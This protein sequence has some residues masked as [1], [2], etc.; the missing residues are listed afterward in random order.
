VKLGRLAAA[1]AATTLVLSSCS[2]AS[3]TGSSGTTAAGGGDTAATSGGGDSTD[4][5]TS[6][7]GGA[8]SSGAD[9]G[10]SAGGAPASDAIVKLVLTQDTPTLLPMDSTGGDQIGVLDVVYD[11]LV[12]YDPKTT[13]P[14]NY[15][16]SD[17]TNKDNTVWTIKIK[18]GLKFQ[19]GEPVDAAAFARAWNYAAYGPNAMGN[20][21]FFERI[22]G[23]DD[24]QGDY[25]VDDNGKVT[26]NEEPKAKELSGL[27]IVDPLT[28]QVTLNAPF[29]GFAT[30]LG[31]TGFFPIAK[32]CLDDIPACAVKP[33]GNG[34]FKI[35]EWDQGQKLTAS[36]WDGYTLDETPNYAGI[37]WTEYK[38]KSS[39]P[40]F[41]GGDID[42]SSPPP[43]QWAAANA[44]PDLT[45]RKVSGPGAALTYIGFPEY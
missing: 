22:A 45:S 16:A 37:E 31:Y 19:N 34:P 29:S 6:G 15:V 21:Y 8:A 33:I 23:Y 4:A 39:W 13:K 43:A 41:Q 26:V 9:A 11:G 30:M 36:K 32:A 7:S 1:I 42:V 17:I 38:G 25:D 12:R 35:D 24:M 44:D 20:N 27:K 40:D 10:P 3:D 14:H 2:S 5:A 18:D 28:L